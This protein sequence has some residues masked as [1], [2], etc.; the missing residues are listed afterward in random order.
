VTQQ[1][2]TTARERRGPF[3]ELERLFE[4]LDD[5]DL[6]NALE[7]TR[8]TGRPGYPLRVMWRTLVASFYLGI[9]HDTDLV[10]ALDSNPLLALTCGIEGRDGVPSKFAY[11]RFRRKLTG[12]NEM[13]ADVLSRAVERL[14]ATLPG[15]GENVAVDATDIHAWANGFHQDTDPD[16]GTGAK[17]KPHTYYWYGYKVHLAVDAESELPIWF[18]LTPANVYDGKHLAP[19]LHEAQHRFGWFGPQH[20]MADK[21]YDSRAC[22]EYVGSLGAIPVIDVKARKSLRARE[23]RE[24]E[25]M[26][27][28][29]PTGTRYRCERVPYDQ[30][31]SR[32]GKCPLLPMFVDSPMNDGTAAPYYEQH[33]PFPYGSREWKLLYNKRV[34]VE[35]VFSRLKT[36]R[37]LDAIRTRR[38]PKVWLHVAM[39]LLAMLGSAVASDRQSVR[40]CVA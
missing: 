10:R 37:K 31:C 30:H 18:E 16:A 13:I 9:I 1:K 34:S 22:F 24:C 29:T 21:G 4:A 2:Y 8:W 14:R 3:E 27:V 17:K 6:L 39:S 23:K 20:V 28:I 33:S 32:F 36:Y 26:P 11:C 19:V 38:L 15:F 12:F 25:A 40:R 5:G 7:A 35:R